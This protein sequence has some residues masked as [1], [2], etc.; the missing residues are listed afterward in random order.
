MEAE[1]EE[2]GRQSKMEH[3]WKRTTTAELRRW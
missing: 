2:S 1:T 3:K